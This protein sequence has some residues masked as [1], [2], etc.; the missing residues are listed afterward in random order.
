MNNDD[1]LKLLNPFLGQL[2]GA[3][4]TYPKLG[5]VLAGL[6]KVSQYAK[7]H[8]LLEPGQVANHIHLIVTGIARTFFFHEGRDTTTGFIDEGGV[9][10]SQVSF[11]T[12]KP[13]N[14]GIELLEQTTLI[15]LSHEDYEH[16]CRQSSMF[17]QLGKKLAERFLIQSEKRNHLLR[18]S[19]PKD[20]FLNFAST[21]KNLVGRIA[22][23]YLASYLAMGRS[24]FNK[25]KTWANANDHI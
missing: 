7:K 16:V 8:I 12:R 6:V 11:Y 25:I 4:N 17:S 21:N 18:I 22:D 19:K 15:S 20:K 24:T 2:L 13:G 14:E 10:T 23:D 9:A 5:E 3:E 1:T